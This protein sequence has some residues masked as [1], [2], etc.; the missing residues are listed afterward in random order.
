MVCSAI[1]AATQL[2]VPAVLATSCHTAIYASQMHA[3][4]CTAAACHVMRSKCFCWLLLVVDGAAKET[5]CAHPFAALAYAEGQFS[6]P[7]CLTSIQRGRHCCHEMTD[8]R[9][10]IWI[11]VQAAAC[12]G[13]QCSES[14]CSLIVSDCLR[15]DISPHRVKCS[16]VKHI[17]SS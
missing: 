14:C 4:A 11:A 3:F 5:V 1:P 6:S 15:L 13:R 16:V 17:S 2:H 7:S 12:Q 9:Q 10:V 8:K